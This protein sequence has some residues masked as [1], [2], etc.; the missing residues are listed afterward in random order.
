MSPLKFG[1][2]LQFFRQCRDCCVRAFELDRI[3][4]VVPLLDLGTLQIICGSCG[5]IRHP[6]RR[7]KLHMRYFEKISLFLQN[8]TPLIIRQYVFMVAVESPYREGSGPSF[9]DTCA[10]GCG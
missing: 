10:V 4:D 2:R 5:Y 8:E 1:V 7:V 3:F 6:M 9:I